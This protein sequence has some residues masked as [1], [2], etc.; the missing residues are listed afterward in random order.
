MSAVPPKSYSISDFKSRALHLAQTSLYQLTIVPPPRIF[1]QTENISLL[2]HEATLPGS[3]L[4]TH[5]VTNDH[6]GVTEKMAYR[7]MYDESFNL[8]FYV[9]HQYNVVDFFEKWIEFVVGQGYTQSRNSYREDTAFYRMTYPVDYKQTIY[10]SKFEKD[11]F[12]PTKAPLNPKKRGGSNL[13]YEL[14][15]AFP[16]NIVS[17]P[18]SYNQSDI[19]KCSVGFYFIRYVVE[20]K[21]TVRFRAPGFANSGNPNAQTTPPGTVQR[22]INAFDYSKVTGFRFD[23]Y[24]NNFGVDAQNN[25][26]FGNFF[27]GRRVDQGVFGAEAQA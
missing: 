12:R 20:K 26:N 23:E 15:G 19:L 18:V 6:H 4:A 5:Q 2:C 3:S 11:Y 27:D 7:R 13:E 17:M 24:Y 16:Y 25:T 14:I 1:Q 22:P 8:T 21:G 9:D 10:I